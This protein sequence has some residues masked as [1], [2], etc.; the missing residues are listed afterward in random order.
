MTATA[1]LLCQHQY[2]QQRQRLR[3]SEHI[4]KMTVS[5]SRTEKDLIIAY[6]VYHHGLLIHKKSEQQSCNTQEKH[7]Y[8][9]GPL[10]VTTTAVPDPMSA[11]TSAETLLRAM[12]FLAWRVPSPFLCKYQSTRLAQSRN[13]A[14]LSS[15]TEM[16]VH[17][18]HG[19]S[20]LK[21]SRVAHAFPRGR[22]CPKQCLFCN[23]G[24][25]TYLP[26][27]HLAEQ[28]AAKF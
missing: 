16:N 19:E 4:P 15:L 11:S 6:R 7:R 8:K 24:T 25:A 23:P 22:K 12:S 26:R 21:Y 1:T 27:D 17:G 13:I 28:A 18:Y 20:D 3:K 2:R 5:L 14:R 9:F 10:Q